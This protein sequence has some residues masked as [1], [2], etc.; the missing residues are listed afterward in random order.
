MILI[1]FLQ[2]VIPTKPYEFFCIST[3][4]IITTATSPTTSPVATAANSP[5]VYVQ[6][7]YFDFC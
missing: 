7:L 1:L 5:T 4:S 3:D 6:N 2:V